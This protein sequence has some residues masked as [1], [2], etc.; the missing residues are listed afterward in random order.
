M[1]KIVDYITKGL[2]ELRLGV[3]SVFTKISQ[4]PEPLDF[5]CYMSIRQK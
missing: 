1:Y 5:I 3:Y 2:F 4:W